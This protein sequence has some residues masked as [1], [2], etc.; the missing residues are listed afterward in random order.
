MIKVEFVF[1]DYFL[2]SYIISNYTEDRFLNYCLKDYKKDLVAFQNIAWSESEKYSIAIDGRFGL[3]GLIPSLKNNKYQ[4]LGFKLD[5]YIEKLIKTEVY[6]I[7]KN[8]TLIGL[9]QCEKEWS[10]NFWDTNKYI[11]DLGIKIEGDFK[12]WIT[13]PGLR[14]GRNIGDNNIIWSYQTYW[15]NYNTIYIWHEILHSFFNHNNTEHALIELITDNQMKMMLNGVPYPPF[16][17]HDSLKCIK[18]KIVDDWKEYLNSN[19]K[20]LNDFVNKLLSNI[21]KN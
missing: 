2:V 13:H 15:A 3:A 16:E 10:N 21:D 20:D 18:E 17:G 9:Q 4:T 14:A 6:K 19:N 11:K 8:Q 1:N 7:L 12:I 5:K